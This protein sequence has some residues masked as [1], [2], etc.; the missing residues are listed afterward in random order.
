MVDET[1]LIQLTKDELIA[2][3]Q[4]AIN[5]GYFKEVSKISREIDK[6]ASTEEKAE[7]DAKLAVL[8]SVED[9]IKSAFG[10][11]VQKVID[12][13]DD[14]TLKLMDGVWY[15]QDFESNLVTCKLAKKG[16]T[17]RKGG[18]G[19][20][21]KRFAVTTEELLAKHGER[22]ADETTGKTFNELWAEDTGKNSRYQVRVKLLKLNG[23][24]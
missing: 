14:A 11:V 16:V 13:L 15:T 4:E 6:L 7:Q 17:V 24:A 8:V 12:S 2:K 20:V 23:D 19:G 18:G 3:M 10:K 22:I 21:G 5:S 1:A 9:G